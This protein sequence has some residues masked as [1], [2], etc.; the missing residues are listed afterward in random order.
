MRSAASTAFRTVAVVRQIDGIHVLL[1]G[2][3]VPKPELF[4]LELAREV[5]V[6]ELSEVGELMLQLS[7]QTAHFELVDVLRGKEF[8]VVAV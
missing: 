3:E 8:F 6:K 2:G 7:H 5:I 1:V 4:A